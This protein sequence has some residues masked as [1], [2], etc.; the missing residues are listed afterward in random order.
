MRNLQDRRNNTTD[1]RESNTR[2]RSEAEGNKV[3]DCQQAMR[4]SFIQMWSVWCRLCWVIYCRHLHQRNAKQRSSAIEKHFVDIHGD[5]NLLDESQVHVLKKF[6][7]RFDCLVCEIPFTKKLQTF[8][9]TFKLWV[10]LKIHCFS[11]LM[12][13]MMMMMAMIMMVM[14]IVDEW[15]W[16]NDEWWCNDDEWW[17]WMMM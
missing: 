5:K 14:V 1:F 15:W 13:M 2:A 12:M 4:C 10:L 17:W 6:L 9:L 11:L 7:G 16:C 3:V 8:Y